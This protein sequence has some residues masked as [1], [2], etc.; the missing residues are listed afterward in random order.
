M[1]T[2]LSR[3]VS[4]VGKRSNNEDSYLIIA[5]KK[6]FLVCDGVGGA[7]KGEVASKL[8]C[9][10]FK[11]F[12]VKNNIGFPTDENIRQAL[13]YAENN[14]NEYLANN[15][16]SEGMA[17]T[18]TFLAVNENKAI[19]AHIGDSRVYHIR[20]GKIIYVTPDHSLVAEMVA[21]G[22]IT[23]EEAI[24]HPR[25]NVISRAI[26]GSSAP[27]EVEIIT[28]EG[29]DSNDFFLLCTDGVL[30][31]VSAEFINK[32]FRKEN[33]VDSIVK[34]IEEICLQNS[35][36]NF[37]AIVV[38]MPF[39]KTSVLA[40]DASDTLTKPEEG[41]VINR[42]QTAGQRKKNIWILL[43]IIIG[44]GGYWTYKLKMATEAKK[45]QY[46]M[47]SVS[48]FKKTI[49]SP[50]VPARPQTNSLSKKDSSNKK[51]SLNK[52]A[53]QK[54]EHQKKTETEKNA[55]VQNKVDSAAIKKRVISAVIDANASQNNKPAA[56]VNNLSKPA[57]IVDTSAQ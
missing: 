51:D 31:S 52:E 49:T 40:N 10:S 9:D 22:Y 4:N 13:L 16:G 33:T 26:Q 5:E 7:A 21:S 19:I 24:N 27:A 12:F 20:D 37:T 25:K 41:N 2:L 35:K 29:L 11:T 42:Q 43:L 30:E 44:G 53:K 54:N 55:V 14:F 50:T 46:S 32:N 18:L 48:S 1:E 6:T 38:Q 23:P 34:G 3:A 45:N 28:I 57:A 47:D 39:L 56:P 8:C 15:A 36:D 17:T